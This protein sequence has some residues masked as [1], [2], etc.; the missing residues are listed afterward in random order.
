MQQHTE[1]LV[2]G[3]GPGGYTAAFR[4]AD[5]GKKVT[6]VERFSNLG[7]VCLNV[8]CIPSKAL[9]HVSKVITEAKHAKT[10]GIEFG[11]STII[12]EKI[13]DYKNKIIKKLTGGLQH[14]AKRRKV[15]LVQGEAR[16]INANTIKVEDPKGKQL[17]ITF[18][19]AIIAAGSEPTRLPFLPDDPR[20]MTSTGALKLEDIPKSLLILGGGIIGLEMAMI[21]SGLGSKITVVELGSQLI[22]NADADLV[23]PLQKRLSANCKFLLNTKLTQIEVKDDGLWPTLEGKNASEGMQAYDKVLIAVGRVPNG[24]RIGGE[25]IGLD[26]DQHGFIKVDKQLRT[27]IP[28]IFAIGD[29]VGQPMLAHKASAEG[30]I[31]A[32]VIAGKA[33]HTFEPRCIASVAYTDPELAWVGLNETEAKAKNI[34]YEKGVFPWAASGRA[35]TQEA[36]DGMTKLLFE[37]KTGR[38]LGGGIVG[39]GAGELISEIALGIEMGCTAQDI[40]LTIHPHPTLSETTL[41]AT[42]VFEKTI[43]DL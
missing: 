12:P 8:G 35:L 11:E 9:L 22:P 34:A 39:T 36:T 18:D 6:L 43:T 16:F 33:H 4:A 14:L 38:L 31:A 30:K 27:N 28:H 25:A 15:N 10:Y 19:H 24:K 21:Y 32:E 13:R 37:P 42:E 17:E 5:L 7:G 3:S 41:L 26:I 23:K 20:I 40:A 29:I 2:L 1:V